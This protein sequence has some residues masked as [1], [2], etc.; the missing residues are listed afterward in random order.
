MTLLSLGGA[1]KLSE[2][3]GHRSH[4]GKAAWRWRWP[5]AVN[6]VVA[7]VAVAVAMVVALAVNMVAVVV[8]VRP[9]RK[10]GLPS[11]HSRWDKGASVQS[12]GTRR[13]G[14]S[15]LRKCGAD[16]VLS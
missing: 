12:P 8:A 11:S 5:V 14:A 6:M 9:L 13:G 4:V 2:W 1:R 15:P 10:S 7:M 16:T 3:A